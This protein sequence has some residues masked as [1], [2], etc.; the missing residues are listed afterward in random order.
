MDG[1][2]L[3]C[4]PSDPNPLEVFLC[5]D[6]IGGGMSCA[7]CHGADGLTEVVAGFTAFPGFLANENPQE[8]QHKARFGHPGTAMVKTY[9]YG[10]TLTD[11]ADLSAYSQTL[12]CDAAGG[13]WNPVTEACE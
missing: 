3:S 10:S 9:D 7:V 8:F 2:S 5:D 12:D 13:T 6:G 1:S 11:I 4:Q